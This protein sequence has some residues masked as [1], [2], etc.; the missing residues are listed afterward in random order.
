MNSF[1]HGII[2]SDGGL[3]RQR[4]PGN[5]PWN[6]L[7]T[8]LTCIVLTCFVLRIDWTH[9]WM[10]CQLLWLSSPYQ[11]L[12]FL[13]ILRKAVPYNEYTVSVHYCLNVEKDFFFL[14]HCILAFHS[15]QFCCI[16]NHYVFCFGRRHFVIKAFH[17][18]RGMISFTI[19][20]PARPVFFHL[21]IFKMGCK[22]Q[23]YSNERGN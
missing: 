17:T 5:W 19:N 16:Y 12:E 23:T 8:R 7:D 4:R 14:P 3:G 20:I 13:Q 10:Y 22:T 2:V 6:R 18:T 11:K 15:V 21:R 9:D 1:I